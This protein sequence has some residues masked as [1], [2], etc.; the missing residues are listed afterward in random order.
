MKKLLVLNHKMYLDF[1]DIKSYISEI[2]D[3]IRSDIDV[4][5]CP[6]DVFIPYFKG[7]YDFKLGAQNITGLFVTGEASAKQLKSLDV[8]YSLVGHSDRK[9][10]FNEDSKV[11][12]A[13]IIEA[14]NNNIIPIVCVGE[15][16]EERE[17]RKTADVIVKQ[18]KDYFRDIDVNSDVI[19]A[20]EPIWSIGSGDVLSNKDIYEVVDLIK[21][22]IFKR[23]GVNISV[24]YGGS[25]DFK[26]IERLK[27]ITNLDGF[28][29]GKMSTSSSSVLKI[30][31]EM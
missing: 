2:K 13:N 21:S 27:K 10:Y 1:N 19:I 5:V 14:I 23:Y 18:L 30:M 28:L 7:R 20:Y 16:K 17:R 9:L 6:S 11:I 22:V 4:V 31:N 25:V 8:R 26:N 15:T 29:L 12:N 24:I 3:Y